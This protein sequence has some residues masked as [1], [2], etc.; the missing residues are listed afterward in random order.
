MEILSKLLQKKSEATDPIY[1][2]IQKPL[3]WLSPADKAERHVEELYSL[4]QHCL[5]TKFAVEIMHQFRPR[6]AEM[7]FASTIIE[8]FSEEVIHKGDT[9]PDFYLEKLGGWAEV[10]TPG[11]G[12]KENPSSIPSYIDGVAFSRPSE[13]IMLRLAHAFSVRNPPIN[14]RS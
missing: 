1:K 8:R 3:S 7:Y 13:Q 2:N 5:D 10:V 11:D 12:I 4:S 6:Y 14:N 9:G